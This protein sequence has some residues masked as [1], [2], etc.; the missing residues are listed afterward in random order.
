MILDTVTKGVDI[1]LY[2][3]RMDNSRMSLVRRIS[4]IDDSYRIGDDNKALSASSSKTTISTERQI[5]DLWM[6]SF[7]RGSAPDP[8]SPASIDRILPARRTARD[9]SSSA[10]N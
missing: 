7:P 2:K 10:R 5:T 4:K 8:E 3:F 9:P 6:S 1:G